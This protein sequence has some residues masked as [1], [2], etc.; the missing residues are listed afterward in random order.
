M[1]TLHLPFCPLHV[2]FILAFNALA[3]KQAGAPGLRL[4]RFKLS[5]KLS[6]S[7]HKLSVCF[8]LFPREGKG[9]QLQYSG[10]ENSMD[11]IV[12]GVSKS[13]TQLSDFHFSTQLLVWISLNQTWASLDHSSIL[14][15]IIEA[16]SKKYSHWPGRS[17][18]TP[19]MMQN[20]LKRI[21]W[22]NW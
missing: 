2:A 4:I 16:K 5:S 6:L 18:P 15:P 7:Q 17:Q 8:S 9:Y 21:N 3:R 13:Q 11:C 14:K 10:L 1:L 12:H 22:E 19:E 20:H